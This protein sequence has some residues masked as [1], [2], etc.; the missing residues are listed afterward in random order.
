MKIV[1]NTSATSR[2]AKNAS[3]P[4]LDPLKFYFSG[5]GVY[6]FIGDDDEKNGTAMVTGDDPTIR[7]SD[8]HDALTPLKR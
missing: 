2:S 3:K 1:K 6:P 7:S 4:H 8:L 5:G